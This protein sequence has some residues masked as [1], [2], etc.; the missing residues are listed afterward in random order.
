MKSQ[1]LYT[2]VYIIGFIG[3]L[4]VC[5]LLYKKSKVSAEYTRKIGHTASTLST[6]FFPFIFHSYGYVLSIVIF[7]FAL[8]YIG[9]HFMLF[10]SIES[11]ERKTEGSYL[12]PLSICSL[13]LL[14]Q[15]NNLFFI[16][17][18]L[19]LGISD[20][21]AGISGTLYKDRT[22]KIVLFKHEFNKTILGTIVFSIST[23]IISLIVLN[24]F[25]FDSI[26]LILLSLFITCI[27][28]I[29]EVI[30]PKGTDNI[31][32]PHSVLILLYL[33]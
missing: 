18:I 28:A 20:S 13:F 3:L 1:L 29:I 24:L 7:S 17:P 15:G 19:V 9:K 23:F 6:I 22:S 26:K 12:L 4:V 25:H 10:K 11:V 31:T 14:S 16:L 30:S 32:V 5:E 27:A 33:L 21:L 2:F 8:L